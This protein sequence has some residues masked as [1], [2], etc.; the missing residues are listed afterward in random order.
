M[1]NISAMTIDGKLGI[2]AT[3]KGLKQLGVPVK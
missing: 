2:P 3:I 1:L